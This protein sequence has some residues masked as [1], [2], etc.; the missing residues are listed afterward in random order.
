MKW[1]RQRC[2][3]ALSTLATM[4]LAQIGQIVMMTTELGF[5]G[6]IGVE[7]VAAAALA[8][9]IYVLAFTFGSGLL[10]P[11][12]QLAA[13]AYASDRAAPLPSSEPLSPIT[14]TWASRPNG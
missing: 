4:A 8:S 14:R 7:A 3:L 11:A 13:E 12:V 2:Q 6:H 9:K 5:I 10:A 1:T